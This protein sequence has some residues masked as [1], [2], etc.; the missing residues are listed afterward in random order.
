MPNW[1]F[2]RLEIYGPVDQLREIQQR[3]EVKDDY[4]LTIINPMPEALVGSVSPAPASPDP[5]PNWA[6]LLAAGEMT[7]AWHDELV[8]ATRE[9]YENAQRLLAETGYT[10]W[11]AWTTRNWG[12]KWSPQEID[13]TDYTDYHMPHI[14]Y[15]FETPWGPPVPLIESWG[16]A[17]PQ[18]FFALGFTE[19]SMAFTG[20]YV[21]HDDECFEIYYNDESEWPQNFLDQ[22]ALIDQAHHDS[23]NAVGDLYDPHEYY[24]AIDELQNDV[25]EDA[26]DKAVEWISTEMSY[27]VGG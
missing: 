22:R 26:F 6:V 17:Y 2:N 7:Q 9:R 19:E 23:E 11:Y 24:I 4:D 8:A 14:H 12:V 21:A 25:L 18:C 13:F 10:D 16:S 20:V 1:C 3:V 5:H 27:K 15:R